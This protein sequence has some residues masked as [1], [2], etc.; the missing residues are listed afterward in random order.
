MYYVI[1]IDK[2]I[3]LRIHMKFK[4]AYISKQQCDKVYQCARRVIN[5]NILK[6]DLLIPPQEDRPALFHSEVWD[7][8]HI[9]DLNLSPKSKHCKIISDMTNLKELW[10]RNMPKLFDGQLFIYFIYVFAFLDFCA[11]EMYKNFQ[12]RLPMI[13]YGSFK[14]QQMS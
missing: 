11:V 10:F 1:S 6:S 3:Y 12:F 2:S 14:N 4:I 9:E 8:I 13:I 7:N 5:Y